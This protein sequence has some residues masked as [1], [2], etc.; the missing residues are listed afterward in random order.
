MV[1]NILSILRKNAQEHGNNMKISE[2]T[3]GKL[4]KYPPK[5]GKI[6][7]FFDTLKNH[8]KKFDTLTLCMSVWREF[9]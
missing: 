1:W 7:Q 9:P 4:E 5:N 2:K 8:P 6:Q 3:S